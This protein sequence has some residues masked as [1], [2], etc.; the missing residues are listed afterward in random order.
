MN[1]FPYSQV[2][3]YVLLCNY[4]FKDIINCLLLLSAGVTHNDGREQHEKQEFEEKIKRETREQAER[5]CRKKLVKEVDKALK[6]AEA[7]AP[8]RSKRARDWGCYIPVVGAVA[9]AVVGSVEDIV[10]GNGC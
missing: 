5:E 10:H 8:L 4:F 2:L 3:I 1:V 6:E 7:K 9:G